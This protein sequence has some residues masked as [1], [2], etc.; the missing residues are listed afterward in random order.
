M[1][2]LTRSRQTLPECPRHA[3]PIHDQTYVCERC[4]DDLRQALEAV[5]MTVRDLPEPVLVQLPPEKDEEEGR[6]VLA[7]GEAGRNQS[8]PWDS[9]AARAGGLVRDLVLTLT[10][11]GVTGA[12]GVSKAAVEPLPWDE[13]AQVAHERLNKA[14]EEAFQAV[15]RDRG[16]PYGVGF[17]DVTTMAERLLD[18]VQ[19]LRHQHDAETLVEAIVTAV[20][21]AQHVI[22]VRPER[23]ICG[24]CNTPAMGADGQPYVCEAELR[25]VP[26]RPMVR[27]GQC[28]AEHDV[29]YR[30]GW[31]LDKARDQLATASVLASAVT[32]LGQPVTTDRIYQ[33]AHRGRIAAHGTDRRGRPQY[34]VGDV[35]ELLQEQAQAQSQ[36]AS[37]ARR[38]AS[39]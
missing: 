39:A 16:W 38:A 30:R 25:A 26:G 27:C 36:K 22:D 34:R 11:Q 15:V 8:T 29:A 24:P 23:L 20:R 4:G 31:L 2:S 12:G 19:W 13:R 3:T 35:L 33:W 37:Q 10:R 14:I 32:R 5:A 28:G 9:P 18:Q 1:T 6:W 17:V 7:A 21:E